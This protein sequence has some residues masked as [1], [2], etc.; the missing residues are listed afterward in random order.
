M[1]SVIEASPEPTRDRL[2]SWRQLKSNEA[3]RRVSRLYSTETTNRSVAVPTDVAR[4]YADH[5]RGRSEAVDDRGVTN[6]CVLVCVNVRTNLDRRAAVTKVPTVDSFDRAASSD[7]EHDGIMNANVASRKVSRVDSGWGF[8]NALAV[9]HLDEREVDAC[10]AT[11]V[12]DRQSLA[13]GAGTIVASIDAC[14]LCRRAVAKCPFEI[15]DP[16]TAP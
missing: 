9:K 10:V 14:A 7:F 16:V 2:A 15:L 6:L 4:W 3:A 13:V 1:T 12:A 11:V 8:V 5:V